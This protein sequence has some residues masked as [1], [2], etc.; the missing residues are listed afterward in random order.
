MNMQKD[1]KKVVFHEFKLEIIEGA[2]GYVYCYGDIVCIIY[3]D[4][5]HTI[6]CAD[7]QIHYISCPLY[8]LQ[9]ILPSIFF[10]C[11]KS[12]LINLS[13]MI[14]Y[15]YQTMKIVMEGEHIFLLSSRRKSNFIKS[16]K[17]LPTSFQSVSCDLA[18]NHRCDPFR[19]KSGKNET[20]QI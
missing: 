11:N 5:C 9:R 15:D 7:G 2:K 13:R 8:K 1:S 6:Y 10:Q 20:E 17:C 14:S 16:K 18:N 12:T 19:A 3:G 4:P